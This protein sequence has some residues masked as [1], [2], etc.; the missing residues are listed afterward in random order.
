[1]W[2]LAQ[3]G[4][5]TGPLFMRKDGHWVGD[6]HGAFPYK[7]KSRAAVKQ[8]QL[9]QGKRPALRA[10]RSTRAAFKLIDQEALDRYKIE[11]MLGN[12]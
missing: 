6:P 1:M 10:I 7:T 8:N 2:Y 9:T 3:I 11:V 12:E 5:D 4:L